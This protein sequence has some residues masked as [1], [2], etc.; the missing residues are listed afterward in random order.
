[1]K[2][3]HDERYRRLVDRLRSARQ[4]NSLTQQEVA[5]RLG[6]H[7]TTISNIEILERRMDLLEAQQICEIYGIPLES[8][9][10]TLES[11][12]EH[13]GQTNR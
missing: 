11:Q 5:E 2:T 12:E 8:L 13:N 7:R 9:V 1:M 3:I 4:R 6:W 10:A